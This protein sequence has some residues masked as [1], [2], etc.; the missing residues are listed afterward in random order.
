MFFF[1][2]STIRVQN[3]KEDTAMK[4][5]ITVLLM[6]SLLV[7]LLSTCA[8]E[9]M[10][11]NP[12]QICETVVIEMVHVEEGEHIAIVKTVPTP[13]PSFEPIQLIER[14]ETA[15][16]PQESEINAPTETPAQTSIPK[17]TQSKTPE[18]SQVSERTPTPQSTPEPV[19]QSTP[20]PQPAPQPIP[21][22]TPQPTPPPVVIVTPPPARTI[23]NTCEADITGNLVEHGTTHLINDENFSYR[24]E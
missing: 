2:G 8:D 16:N 15:D 10:E 19:E 12:Q 20:T 24:N 11:I 13:E 17:P 6:V 7:L 23:C 22:Q 18:T 1:M 3:I 4:K 14:V 5:I 21:E 9:Q